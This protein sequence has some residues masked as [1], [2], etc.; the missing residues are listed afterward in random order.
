MFGELTKE[1][2][3]KLVRIA[4][5]VYV[6]R[7]TLDIAR[8]VQ[9]YD[10]N[11]RLKWCDPA[12]ASISD[13]PYMITEI[14]PDGIERVVM[15]IFELNASVIERLHA[16]DTV[17]NNVLLGLDDH[18]NA[19]RMDEQRRY[20]EERDEVKDILTHYLK[21]PGTRWSFRDPKTD[22]KITLDSQEGIPAKVEG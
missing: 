9:E 15:R 18:N 14:C 11:L 16:A 19:I 7:D 12:Q 13:A 2:K 1:E 3:E 22:K 21:A 10:S 17:K 20:K 8:R 6:E 4:D 5:G